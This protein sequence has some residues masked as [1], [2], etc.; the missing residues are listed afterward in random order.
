MIRETG[1]IFISEKHILCP[2]FIHCSAGAD[3]PGD[4]MHCSYSA[5]R[6]VT[7]HSVSP[8]YTLLHEH[9]DQGTRH[10]SVREQGIFGGRQDVCNF[11]YVGWS[12]SL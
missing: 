1:R 10:L 5:T 2:V 9:M 6:T 8:M 11:V 7:D 3:P 12:C 4:L